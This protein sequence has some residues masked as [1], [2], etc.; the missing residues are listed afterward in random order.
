[1]VGGAWQILSTLTDEYQT[2]AIVNSIQCLPEFHTTDR[3]TNHYTGHRWSVLFILEESI[4]CNTLSYIYLEVSNKRT[5]V[6]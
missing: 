1:M 2:L 4:F 3:H 6:V 5:H